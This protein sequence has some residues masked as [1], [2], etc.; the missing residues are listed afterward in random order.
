LNHL[1]SGFIML[2]YEYSH[3]LSLIPRCFTST[4]FAR[5]SSLN[6]A[7][8]QT[9][10]AARMHYPAPFKGQTRPYRGFAVPAAVTG[11][12]APSLHGVRGTVVKAKWPTVVLYNTCRSANVKPDIDW[13][14][15][16]F[17]I[18]GVA[19]VRSLDQPWHGSTLLPHPL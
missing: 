8:M 19:P 13:E 1:L 18:Q 4:L 11:R 10:L 17:G 9:T 7:R 2:R 14:N 15:L 16:S 3:F 6:I 12:S 5:C